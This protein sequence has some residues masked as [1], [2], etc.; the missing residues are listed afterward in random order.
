MDM[1]A[2]MA[3]LGV[4]LYIMATDA[5]ILGDWTLSIASFPDGLSSIVNRAT[6]RTIAGFGEKLQFGI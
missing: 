4:K 1:A 2:A 5:A 3:E 6:A